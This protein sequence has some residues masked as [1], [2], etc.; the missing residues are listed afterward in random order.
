MRKSGVRRL[1]TQTTPKTPITLLTQNSNMAMN[2]LSIYC[3]SN[4]LYNQEKMSR[5]GPGGFH[6]VCLGDTFKEG[7]YKI[8]HKLGWGG[9]STVWL[10][11][12]GVYA[13]LLHIKHLT[14]SCLQMRPQIRDVGVN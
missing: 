7:R 13:T 1:P 3:S 11:W 6:P 12:D 10:A 4:L 9:F 2:D 5:Y 8:C 14:G